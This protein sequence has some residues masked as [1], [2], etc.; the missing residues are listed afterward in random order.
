MARARQGVQVLQSVLMRSSN[1]TV[2][3][4]ITWPISLCHCGH[5]CSEYVD[6]CDSLDDLHIIFMMVAN[7][8]KTLP[9]SYI[10]EQLAPNGNVTTAKN[11][12]YMLQ[13]HDHMM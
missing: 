12:A 3:V 4:A 8:A 11:L 7:L 6:E 1:V 9:I 13:E 10:S 5:Q 2:C